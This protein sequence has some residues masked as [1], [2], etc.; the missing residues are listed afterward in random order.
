ME[1]K[2]A[3][4]QVWPA[5]LLAMLGQSVMLCLEGTQI[6]T[7]LVNKAHRLQTFKSPVTKPASFL[8]LKTFQKFEY[9]P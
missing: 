6:P 4:N 3:D 7:E 1:S 5:L 8:L 9:I 2:P